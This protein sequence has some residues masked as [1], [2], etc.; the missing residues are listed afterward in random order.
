MPIKTE[1]TA[2]DKMRD[3]IEDNSALLM[4]ISRFGISLGFGDSTIAEVCKAQDVDCQTFLAVVNFISH[5]KTTGGKISLPSLMDY[6]I[7]A[8]TYFLDFQLPS[9]RRRLIEAINC[10]DEENVSTLILKFFDN[11][12]EEV[13]KHMKHENDHVFVYVNGLLNN[14]M[15]KNAS[16]ENYSARHNGISAKLKELKDI[17]I[18]YYPQKN[19]D[20]I[21][22]VLFDIIVCEQDLISHCEIEDCIFVPEVKKLEEK[23]KRNC[24]ANESE[25]P[26]EP[27]ND[28]EKIEA[29]TEREKDIIRCVAKGMPN[30]EIA[31]TLNLS[32]H[33]VTTHRRNLSSKLQIHS[34]AGL[35]IFAILN[36]LVSLEEVKHL[37]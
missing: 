22:S 29:L 14:K 24:D 26:E 2:T 34:P 33:T 17:I 10:R 32:I 19:S 36:K 27:G 20:L 31:D 12:V 5:K 23:V 18:R 11:Y 35:T 3:I 25:L 30:K 13:N 15:R 8:H 7:N 37:K 6:L 1:Y 16:I 21:N 28:E 4:A 9:I